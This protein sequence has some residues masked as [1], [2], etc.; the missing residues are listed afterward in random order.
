MAKCKLAPRANFDR[1][2][3]WLLIEIL[4][5]II[6]IGNRIKMHCKGIEE[7]VLDTNAG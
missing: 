6:H 3:C 1:K 5:Y 2:S 4:E 7:H